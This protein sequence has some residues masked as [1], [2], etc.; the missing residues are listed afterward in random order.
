M[1]YVIRQ[2][3][4][5]TRTTVLVQ[6][7]GTICELRKGDKT[8]KLGSIAQRT[9]LSL[10]DW[11]REES[12]E[13]PEIKIPGIAV[14]SNCSDVIK[15]LKCFMRR[16]NMIKS[17][18]SMNGYKYSVDSYLFVMENDKLIPFYVC[19]DGYMMYKYMLG[20]TFEQLELINPEFWVK[21]RGNQIVRYK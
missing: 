13:H 7:D 21:D 16:P 17:S 18:N 14:S 19:S 9:W 5:E 3:D 6:D 12:I 20:R 2:G 8:Y 4:G 15:V 1:S 11:I 10:D